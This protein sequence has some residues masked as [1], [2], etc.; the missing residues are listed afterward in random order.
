MRCTKWLIGVT[1]LYCL[2]LLVLAA[3]PPTPGVTRGNFYRLRIGMT[4][5]ETETIF[6]GKANEPFTTRHNGVLGFFLT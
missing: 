5:A 3:I 6:G 4:K 2:G 1:S